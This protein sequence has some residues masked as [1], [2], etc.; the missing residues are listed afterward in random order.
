MFED[1]PE[2]E[3]DDPKDKEL[4]F[5]YNRE[6][7]IARAPESVKKYYRGE[8]NPVR[9]IKVFFLPQNRWIFFFFFFFVGATWLYTGFNK[10]R[11]WA[12]A[13]GLNFE[14]SAFSYEEQVYSQI[15]VKRSKKSKSTKPVKVDAEF[16]VIDPNNQVGDKQNQSMVY[17]DG[18]QYIRAK[19]TDFDIIRV[20]VI[21]NVD[22]EEKELSASVKR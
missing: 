1:V 21:L 3:P 8:M 10:T 11:E 17:S 7:R 20:D 18:Q 22:G 15:E 9:G 4:H 12:A 14:L 2:I 6:E 16:F 19:F 13:G 5:F